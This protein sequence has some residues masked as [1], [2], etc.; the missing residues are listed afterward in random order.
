MVALFAVVALVILAGAAA[1]G[2]LVAKGGRPRTGL[3]CVLLG[4][5]TAVTLFVAQIVQI[6]YR[7]T[8]PSLV[9][10][11]AGLIA[12]MALFIA[13]GRDV[14]WKGARLAALAGMMAVVVVAFV[15]IAMAMPSGDLF[16]PLFES[17][18]QQMAA[19][20]GFGV[21]LAR[22]EAMFTEYLPVTEMGPGDGVQ[23]QYE[24]FTLVERAVD[25]AP[26]LDDLR[27]ALAP[28]T[29]VLGPGSVRVEQDARYET[30]IVQGRPA[31]TV[32]YKDRSTA[33]KTSFGIEDVRVLAFARDGVL[34]I[35]YSHGWMEYEPEGDIYTPV[36]ALATDELVMIAESLEPAP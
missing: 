15:F 35:V 14:G 27:T 22:D 6:Q 18:A 10:L 1:L 7:P 4:L 19:E 32:E 9:A 3:L 16:V 5:A 23:I 11:G 34:V 17:R 29:E 31:L 20:Q 26:S 8:V 24:R 28:G 21:L 36:D 25:G 12:M 30:T 13:I 33:E 2:W